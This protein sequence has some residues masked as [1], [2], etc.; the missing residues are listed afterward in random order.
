MT[1][2]VGFVRGPVNAE[3]LAAVP[4]HPWVV[5]SGMT[6]AGQT[7]G[8]LYAVH[9]R[10]HSSGEVFPAGVSYRHDRVRFGEL[11]PLDPAQFQP[12]S[13]DVIVRGDG[14]CELY[15]V[16][17]LARESVEVFE[18]RVGAGRPELCWV[19]AVPLPAPL[20]AN[21]VAAVPG[22]GFVASANRHI[23]GP[24]SRTEPDTGAVYE[25]S[26]G[27]GWRRLAGS[28]IDSA[29]GI[30][31]SGD[32]GSVY[33]SGWRSA[34]LKRIPRGGSPAA[35]AS[36]VPTTILTDNLTWTRGGALLA[37]G[38]CDISADAYVA[39]V[40]GSGSP[41][42]PASRVIS[43]DPASLAVETVLEY[44]GGVFGG[45]TSALEV[46]DEIW[47]GSGHHP[48]LA[49]FSGPAAP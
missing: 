11:G 32:G 29:N 34:C 10:D 24:R 40:F 48:D 18:I 12:H 17:H 2:P 38:P 14:A 1:E 23:S 8:R 33:L 20:I 3:D 9:T 28:E 30:A 41:L 47:V 4:S 39:A 42:L 25:W 5:T 46:G 21:S 26:P 6:G 45:A 13:L 16:H 49:R 35:P 22:G 27:D 31:V 15:V 44:P 37:A 36:T 19:G 43:V 7:E